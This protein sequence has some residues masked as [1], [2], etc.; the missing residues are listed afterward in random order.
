MEV[1]FLCSITRSKKITGVSF[2]KKFSKWASDCVSYARETNRPSTRLL[3]MVFALLASFTASSEDWLIIKVYPALL[4]IFSI[5]ETTEDM[6]LLFSR[7][8]IT[9]IVFVL[10]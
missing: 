2:L 4:A 6:K 10:G 5:P 3:N 7:G 1:L 8:R 9:P